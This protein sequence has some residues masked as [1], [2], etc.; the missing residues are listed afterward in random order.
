[1]YS[2]ILHI[3]LTAFDL[4]DS[5]LSAQDLEVFQSST[6]FLEHHDHTMYIIAIVYVHNIVSY[7][8]YPC[9]TYS[10]LHIP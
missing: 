5:N 3:F 7:I 9:V 6:M 8:L 2:L 10:Y 1:M 4:A